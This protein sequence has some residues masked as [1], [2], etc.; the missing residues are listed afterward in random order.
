MEEKDFYIGWSNEFPN[1]SKKAIR[2]LLLVFSSLVLILVFLMV[3]FTKPFNDHVFELGQVRTFTGI[4][5]NDPVPIL[6]LNKG[7]SPI[8]NQNHALLVGYGKNGARTFLD[9]VEGERGPLNGKKIELRGTLIYGDGR[10]LIELTE[11]E[12]SVVEVH[13][14]G[15]VNREQNSLGLRSVTGEILDPKCWFG[16]MKPGEGKVHK[17]CAIRCISG[18]IPPVLRVGREGENEYFVLVG[19][20]KP[21]N[22]EILPFVAEQVD[23]SGTVEEI[24]GWKVLR[25]SIEEINYVKSDKLNGK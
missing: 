2:R 19:D 20:S 16:V 24:N 3:Y 9:P 5:F 10:L 8:K 6:V 14:T 25:T 22:K 17:S 15:P 23:V 13:E 18:G 11:R 1:K 12:N 4:Y 7:Q 21:L